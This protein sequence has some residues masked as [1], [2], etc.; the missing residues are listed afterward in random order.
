MRL[1]IGL[2]Y[3]KN[4]DT[5][6]TMTANLL[7]VKTSGQ[8]EQSVIMKAADEASNS[9]DKSNAANKLLPDTDEM[10]D[11]AALKISDSIARAIN[12]LTVSV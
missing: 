3:T 11:N 7:R 6:P 4:E 5:M 1:V 9:C 8:A 10:K 12:K 2:E